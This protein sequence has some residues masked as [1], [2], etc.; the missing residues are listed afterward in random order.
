MKKGISMGALARKLADERN[1]KVDYI[2]NTA[3]IKY[4]DGHLLFNTERSQHELSLSDLVHGQLA[5]WA[6]I[7]TKYYRRMLAEQHELLA[8]NLN[9]WFGAKSASRLLR[10]MMPETA[11][12]PKARNFVGSDYSNV[13]DMRP[14][15]IGSA[16]AFLSDRYRRID[17]WDVANAVLPVLQ[18]VDGTEIV[19]CD[20]TDTR[21]YIKAR[22]PHVAGEVKVGD[23]VESGVV[24]S[25]SEVGMGA[26][27][28][29]P[30]VYRLVCTNGMV[31]NTAT[32]RNHIGARAET[33]GENYEFYS[34]RTLELDDQAILAK[35]ADTVRASA[36]EQYFREHTLPQ[37]QAAADT[38]EV[39][40]PVKAVQV[41]AQRVG[42]RE[43]EGNTVLEHLLRDGD[44]TKWGMANAV[45]RTAEDIA[46][47]DRATEL[48][49]LGHKVITMNA[50]EWRQVTE[51][52]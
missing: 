6:D 17:N 49:A 48:E 28:V 14:K 5:G 11:E 40:K 19:S 51:A 35:V 10:T 25:N 47:Y 7:P 13:T 29:Q 34:D 33:K 39:V 44:L 43:E 22:F 45:T 24:I 15:V 12:P 41:L 26:V 9:T 38:A 42:L 4:D 50:T 37:L 27:V 23:V 18:G 31:V 1:R 8:T 52:A 32:R 20:L 30:F 21:M 46:S 16:R 3:D 2:V 36:D